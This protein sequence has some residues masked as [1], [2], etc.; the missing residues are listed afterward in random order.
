MK[1]CPCWY[2]KI[3]SLDKKLRDIKDLDTKLETRL[4]ELELRMTTR[5][6]TLMVVAVG[7]VATLVKLL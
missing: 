1:R 6:G 5:L 3:S 2:W 4:K 7:A